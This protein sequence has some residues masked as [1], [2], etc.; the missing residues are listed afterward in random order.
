M[1]P[2]GVERA[3]LVVIGSGQGGVPL[4]V[5]MARDGKKVALFERGPFGGT[6]INVGC[7]PSKTLLAAAHAA[8]RARA[9]R[10]LGVVADARVDQSVV[11]QRVHELRARWSATTRGRLEDAGVEIIP[12]QAHFSGLR[13]VTGGGRTIEAPRVVVDVGT[14]P[15]VPDIPGLAG[16][17]VLTNA[18][19]FDLDRFPDRLVVLGGGYI[20]LELGQG[21]QRLGTAVTIVH[22]HEHLLEKEETDASDVLRAALEEDGVRVITGAEAASAAYDNGRFRLVLSSGVALEGEALL[23]ATGRRANT[24]AL[25]LEATGVRHSGAGFIEVDDY[26]QTHCPGVYAIGDCAGQP[27]FTHVSYED[28]RRLLS[29]FRGRPRRRDDRVLSYTTFTEPQLARTG[30]TQAQAHAKGLRAT[31][32][33]LPLSAVARAVEW[34]VERGFFRLVVDDDTDRILGATFV[35]YEAGEL[36]HVIVA[37][38]EAGATWHVLEASMYVHPTLAEGMPTL[39]GLIPTER[40]R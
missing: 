35:G 7:T 2:E 5:Q 13:T 22:P 38:I 15:R 16:T 9:A 26:L 3:D 23:V 27:A 36:I 1:E 18:N 37:H 29:A 12:A 28:H 39:A 14:S 10:R 6:C 20:G 34:D 4:A 8:G 24:E 31:T 32:V 30:L 33:T 11:F 40:R 19:V 17:P 25:H 21:A